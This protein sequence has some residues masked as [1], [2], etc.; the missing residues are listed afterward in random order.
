MNMRIKLTA[1]VANHD[2][3]RTCT[4]YRL[5]AAL[6]AVFRSQSFTRLQLFVLSQPNHHIVWFFLNIRIFVNMLVFRNSFS[7]IAVPV[8]VVLVADLVPS[9]SAA[10]WW[11]M[12]FVME[13]DPSSAI[14]VSSVAAVPILVSLSSAVSIAATDTTAAAVQSTLLVVPA[15]STAIES[16][17]LPTASS[18][19]TAGGTEGAA[20][21]QTSNASASRHCA[22]TRVVLGSAAAAAVLYFVL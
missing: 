9:A 6:Q 13:E 18:S 12:H 3:S 4:P 8:A 14:S 20:V 7:F 22:L 10:P 1:P 5:V 16:S 11:P 15:E 21:K 19:A 2:G 17:S